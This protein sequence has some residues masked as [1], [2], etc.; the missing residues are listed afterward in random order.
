MK[1]AFGN[2]HAA[3][4][5]RAP[6]MEHLEKIGCEVL[7]CGAPSTDSSDYPDYAQQAC[8]AVLDGRCERA[9]LI[10]GTGIGIGMSANKIKGIRCGVVTDIYGARMSRLHNNTNAIALRGRYQSLDENLK[11]LEVWLES[12]FEGGRHQR[13]LDKVAKLEEN[14]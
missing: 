1:I 14:Q 7:D 13:R 5:Q 11:I 10:C 12:E 3:F 9:V 4:E 2:D 6:I 8:Q